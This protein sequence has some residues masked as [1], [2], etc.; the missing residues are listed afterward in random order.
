[1]LTDVYYSNFEQPGRET[2]TS[3]RTPTPRAVL[4]VA[5]SSKTAM[6]MTKRRR[7]RR[8]QGSRD[9]R[10]SLTRLRSAS[11]TLVRRTPSLTGTARTSHPFF[12]STDIRAQ[13]PTAPPT[14]LRPVVW[15]LEGSA[16]Q[17]LSVREAPTSGRASGDQ[18][19]CNENYYISPNTFNGPVYSADELTTC[20]TPSFTGSP[21]CRPPSPPRSRSRAAGPAAAGRRRSVVPVRLRRGSVG[22]VRD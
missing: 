19:A 22:G 7:P 2:S 6:S 3:G 1:V 10:S 5:R 11:M 8:R 14:V 16:Q 12:L 4:R 17:R 13:S 21:R 9:T 18:S 15:Q 20:G